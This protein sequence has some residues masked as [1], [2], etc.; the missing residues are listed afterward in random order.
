MIFPAT[1]LNLLKEQLNQAL[2][3][4]SERSVALSKC[5]AQ[6]T[7]YLTRNDSLCR[8][9]EEKTSSIPMTTDHEVDEQLAE[10]SGHTSQEALQSSVKSLQ[11]M[12][13]QKEETIVRYQSLLKEDR[14]KHS[15]AAA[16]LHEEIS[17]LRKIVADGS[18]KDNAMLGHVY[19]F[20]WSLSYGDD[21]VRAGIG[22]FFFEKEDLL[23]GWINRVR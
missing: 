22:S 8:L 9:L 2:A 20:C 6:L 7:E 14:D 1:N 16:R 17:S 18:N 5:E 13:S 23:R 12:I 11:K 10:K 3:L 4:A 21:F 19:F 15:E